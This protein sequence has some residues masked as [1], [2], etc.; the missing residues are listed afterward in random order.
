MLEKYRTRGT[1]ASEIAAGV[2]AAVSEGRLPPGATLPPV[3]ELAADAGVS[4]GTAAAAYRL[5]RERGVIET[6]GRR[7]TRVR[8][9]P[10][11]TVRE[12]IRI[13]VPPGVRDL[14][15]G[16]PDP[17][18]LPPLGDALA[19]AARAHAERP[20][21]YGTGDDEEL[22]ALAG[23][24]MRADGIPA[25]PV[26][27]T[28]GTLDA[29]ERVLAAHLRPGDA[30]AVE[31]PG[32]AA[33]LD[34]AAT[35]GL[36]TVPMRL[37]DEGPLP[38]ELGRALRA[39]ARAVVITARAQNPT[40]AAVSSARAHALRELLAAYPEV[41]LIE[42]DHG[43]GFVDLPLHPLAGATRRWVL[44]RST[45]KALGP[46]L[47]VAPITGD[48]VTL[49]RLR[50]RQRLA[51]GWVSHLLQRAVAHLWRTDAVD[52]AAVAASY[53]RRRDGLVTAL[54]ARGIRAHGR[55]GLNVWVPVPDESTAITRL[56]SLGWAAAP[57]ARNRL[58][59][60]PA[61]RLTVSTLGEH[62]IDPL[63]DALTT[64]VHPPAPT[65]RYG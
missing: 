22:I 30:V 40:G 13:E 56:L 46:D 8:P 15:K 41:L 61:L 51:A 52:T 48:P 64:A 14:S 31:D 60:P 43:A 7:G 59:T 24:R 23:E 2:E 38:A 49:D 32:W 6:A 26:A 47:R 39:G 53:A 12:E 4:P 5:L 3:R 34:L 18:L 25:G 62:D 9:R 33:L 29:V 42:D 44:T 58:G 1:T 63:A 45:A 16:N 65:G 57:G 37:D 11:S 35:L 10:A 19:A 27:I 21:L 54:A 50:G 28:S 20:A 55:S 17:A 36:R